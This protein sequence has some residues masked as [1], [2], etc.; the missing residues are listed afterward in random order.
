MIVVCSLAAMPQQVSEV[1]PSHLISMLAPE[2]PIVTPRGFP[3]ERHLKLSFDDIADEIPGHVA[4]AE[5][6]IEA[7]LDHATGWDRDDPVVVHCFAGISRS[8]AAALILLTMEANG[9]EVAAARLLRRQAP[10][11]QP[12][13]R[14]IAIADRLLGRDGRLVAA[15]AAMGA[16]ELL[17]FGPAVRLPGRIDI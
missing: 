5:E 15:L 3:P 16:P 7:I 6:H 10:H 1:A 13:P 12:N 17:S 14:M 8:T 2:D 9:H 4:P 11:A